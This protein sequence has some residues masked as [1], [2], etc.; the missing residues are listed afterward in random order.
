MGPAFLSELVFPTSTW[1]IVL[2]GCIWMAIAGVIIATSNRYSNKIDSGS[3]VKH[4]L[5][6]FLIFLILGS[7]LVYFLFSFVPTA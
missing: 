2:R 4:A 3:R 5:G 6:S 7:G 1:G